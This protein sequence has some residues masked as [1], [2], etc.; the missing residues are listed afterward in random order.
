MS[1]RIDPKRK[2]PVNTRNTILVLALSIAA[3]ASGKAFA[4]TANIEDVTIAN[5]AGFMV[6]TDIG[7]G[8]L[9]QSVNAPVLADY[10]S[11]LDNDAANVG[12]NI[13]L[14]ILD[15]PADKTG[16]FDPPGLTTTMT[17]DFGGP[18]QVV[19]SSLVMSDWSD[20]GGTTGNALA[21]EYVTGALAA[22]GLPPPLPIQTLANMFVQ[23]PN[24]AFRVSDPNVAYVNLVDG[25]LKI[26]LEGLYN[27][28]EILND[29]IPGPGG[30]FT[31]E[32]VSEVVKVTYMNQTDYLYGFTATR[33]GLTV[34]GQCP[35]PTS[36]AISA[37]CSYSGNYEVMFM[38]PEP[39]TLA[40]L[41]LGLAGVGW[42]SRRRRMQ[43]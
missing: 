39:A 26:G 23:S 15:S 11:Y 3:I 42:T 8:L 20:D 36:P 40:L 34:N 28:A 31:D 18:D 9:Q 13:E 41:G 7:G 1:D 43:D 24:G 38:V 6:Y 10:A 32:Q 19:L 22:A 25:I 37:T 30:P 5:G 12:D 16:K 35:D 33:T 14:G 21:V 27:A 4:S 29:L 2:L 17:G